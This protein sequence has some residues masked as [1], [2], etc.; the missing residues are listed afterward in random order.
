MT[1]SD[2]SLAEAPRLEG[3]RP[4]AEMSATGPTPSHEPSPLNWQHALDAAA[5]RVNEKW[6]IP[7]TGSHP[8]V[9]LMGEELAA[10]LCA[11]GFLTEES[12]RM[13]WGPP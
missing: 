10:L 13:H 9:D 8:S 3:P 12:D 6:I 11:Y 5:A 2:L 7:E 4:T 1:G